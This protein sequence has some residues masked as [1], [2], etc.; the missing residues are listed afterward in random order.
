MYTFVTTA[1]HNVNA[2]TCVFVVL[3]QEY[4]QRNLAVRLSVEIRSNIDAC[5]FLFLRHEEM[6]KLT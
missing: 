6:S 5:V 4:M 2:Y 1:T 3:L